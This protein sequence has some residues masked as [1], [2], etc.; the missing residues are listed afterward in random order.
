MFTLETLESAQKRGAPILCEVLGF[1]STSAAGLIGIPHDRSLAAAMQAALNDAR[2][3]PCDIDYIA[4]Q[5]TGSRRGDLAE[6]TAIIQAFGECARRIAVSSTKAL[7]GHLVGASGALGLAVG[8]LA[9]REQLVPATSNLRERDDLLGDLDFIPNAS[10][11]SA[12]VRRVLCN[13]FS[14]GDANAVLVLG[15][16]ENR[17]IWTR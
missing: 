13:S 14:F 7:H 3:S 9:L 2:L 15:R 5:G 17:Y 1:G 16:A 10:R 6:A 12:Q 4:A 11:S 8:I